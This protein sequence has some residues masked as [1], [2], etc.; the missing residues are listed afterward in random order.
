[1][2]SLW[3][4]HQD[5]G[6]GRL[7]VVPPSTIPRLPNPQPLPAQYHVRQDSGSTTIRSVHHSLLPGCSDEHLLIL[8]PTACSCKAVSGD[9]LGTLS[10]WGSHHKREMMVQSANSHTPVCNLPCMQGC[11]GRLAGGG[12]HARDQLQGPG[13]AGPPPPPHRAAGFGPPAQICPGMPPL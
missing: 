7:L 3:V 1:M 12:N 6:P 2:K 4:F 13:A 9:R 11:V 5:L 8:A 10:G